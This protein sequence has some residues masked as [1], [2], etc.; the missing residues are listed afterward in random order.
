MSRLS[1]GR[2]RPWASGLHTACWG[3]KKKGR[4]RRVRRR[5]NSRLCKE[6][7]LDRLISEFV[8]ENVRSPS[9]DEAT[10]WGD[11][12][13]WTGLSWQQA[14]VEAGQS[15][16]SEPSAGA[17]VP[18][19]ISVAAHPA[20]RVTLNRRF[21]WPRRLVDRLQKP[22]RWICTSEV[23]DAEH[24]EGIHKAFSSLLSQ[25]D[26][27][28]ADRAYRALYC[29]DYSAWPVTGTREGIAT[30]TL[31]DGH[32]IILRAGSAMWFI[33]GLPF[34]PLSTEDT[35]WQSRCTLLGSG[36]SHTSNSLYSTYP[37]FNKEFWNLGQFLCHQQAA[38]PLLPILVWLH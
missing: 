32:Q 28:F 19:E 26:A 1:R 4:V 7:E 33:K 29:Y 31:K 12:V 25:N 38:G 20:G 13:E 2:S 21:P 15:N 22:W 5:R 10:C 8:Y 11:R 27:L 34:L 35:R 36:C 30:P 14:G 18:G 9:S 6:R 23:P 17:R 3:G 16:A 37:I 24:F